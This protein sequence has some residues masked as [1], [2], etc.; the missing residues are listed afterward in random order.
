LFPL[1]WDICSLSQNWSSTTDVFDFVSIDDLKK[2]CQQFFDMWYSLEGDIFF[3]Q[4]EV[5]PCDL[6][7]NELTISIPW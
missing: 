3:L 1:F 6:Q 7:I 5:I 4:R 2:I